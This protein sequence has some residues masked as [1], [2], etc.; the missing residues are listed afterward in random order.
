MY[1][2]PLNAFINEYTSMDKLSQVFFFIFYIGYFTWKYLSYGFVTALVK[3]TLLFVF[4]VSVI[5]I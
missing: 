1:N 3:L 2:I 4:V 5:V